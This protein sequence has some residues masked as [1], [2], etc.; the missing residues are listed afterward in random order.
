MQNYNARLTVFYNSF[1]VDP[2]ATEDAMAHAI[3]ILDT[4]HKKADF[5]NIV[6]KQCTYLTHGERSALLSLLIKLEELFD[7]TLSNWKTS[8]VH[9]SLKLKDGF[10]PY[11]GKVYPVPTIHRGTLY[12]Q[13]KRLKNWAY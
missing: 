3:T 11:H 2:A 10:M 7:G 12:I 13:V 6:E 9:L 5:Q 1:Y 8:H 4:K